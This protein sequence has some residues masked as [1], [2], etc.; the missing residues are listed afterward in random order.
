MS[1]ITKAGDSPDPSR[2]ATLANTYFRMLSLTKTAVWATC[3]TPVVLWLTNVGWAD[4]DHPP[5]FWFFWKIPFYGDVRVPA[6]MW[7]VTEYEW[8]VIPKV[9]LT[10]WAAAILQRLLSRHNAAS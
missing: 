7:V 3:L 5:A 4:Q 9:L 6:W 2:R 10:L 8:K 1:P